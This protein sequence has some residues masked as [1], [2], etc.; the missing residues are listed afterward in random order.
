MFVYR[1]ANALARRG[2]YV[3]VIHCLDAYYSL[4]SSEPEGHYPNHSRVTVHS[5]KSMAGIFSPLLTQQLGVPAFKSKKIRAILDNGQ[6]DV[7]HYHNV[8]LIG[9]PK[10]LEYG[11]A[12][13]L[14]TMHEYWLVCPTHVLFKFNR[15][16]CV[17]PSCFLCNLSY[18]RPPQLWRY[19]GMLKRAV[20]HIDAFIAPSKFTA[21][22]HGSRGLNVPTTVIP[23]FIPVLHNEPVK[24]LTS[25]GRGEGDLPYF[26]FVGRLEKL[27]GLQD[28]IPIFR[29]YQQARLVIVGTGHYQGELKTLAGGNTR[30]QFL[31]ALPY[32]K[33]RTLYANALAVIVPSIC[34][35]T[36]G[37]V[38]VEAFSVKTPVLVRDIG[39]LSEL[40][41]ASGG[42]MLYR[43]PDELVSVLE[44]VRLHPA[45]REQ[46]GEKG[47]AAFIAHWEEEQYVENY[48]KL[49]GDIQKKKCPA[50]ETQSLAP[51]LFEQPVK[52]G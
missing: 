45:W 20:K 28:V 33:L 2:H 51:V 29:E 31:G 19:T 16:A 50:A 8:S 49:I 36:F 25:E 27:K 13:K 4:H 34:Y 42:G 32:E 46:L 10:V 35:E 48:F 38:V 37:Q 30:I 11:H 40:V 52:V 47:Y 14:Y 9:G 41:T 6:F 12:I 18:K 5:L 23:M 21:D 1:L 17:K 43:K 7:I 44:T 24:S 26:L 22:A 3:D 39:C 15:E